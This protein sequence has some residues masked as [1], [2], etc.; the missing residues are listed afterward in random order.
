MSKIV[1]IEP[2]IH[3]LERCLKNGKTLIRVQDLKEVLEE[4]PEYPVNETSHNF[5]IN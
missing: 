4:L 2:L 1:N 5:Y 3:S